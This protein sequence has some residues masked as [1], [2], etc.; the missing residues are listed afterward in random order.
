VVIHG[1]CFIVRRIRHHDDP[2]A[3]C[4]RRYTTVEIIVR[5]C[6]S[7]RGAAR[8]VRRPSALLPPVIPLNRS[9]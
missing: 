4:R 7:R 2:D 8:R 5:E 6:S 1:R 3:R 9:R